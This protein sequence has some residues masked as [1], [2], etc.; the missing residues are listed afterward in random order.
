MLLRLV[1]P[2]PIKITFLDE[3]SRRYGGLTK[4]KASLSL[5]DVGGGAARIY[6]RY[7]KVHEDKRT[8]FGLRREDLRQLEGHPGVICFL[9]QGQSEPLFV[10]FADYE[11]VFHS[12][13][14][15]RDGQY[16]AQ[17]FMR[18]ETTD[19]Y[20]AG[21][22][23]FN[24]DAYFGWERLA[25]IVDRSRLT[26]VPELNHAQVQTL[27]GAIGTIKGYEVWIPASDK[28]GLDWSLARKFECAARIP[29]QLQQIDSVFSEIDVVWIERGLGSVR[30]AF[31]VEYS[32]PIYSGLLRFND[33]HLMCPSASTTY[34]IVS[35]ADRRELFVRQ[36]MRPTFT[37]SHLAEKCTFI[38]YPDV[39]AWHA[40]LAS[41]QGGKYDTRRV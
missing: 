39:F 4:L 36:L 1:V 38:E 16:K 7:S 33:L 14:P 40:R 3:L 8:F 18:D 5:F 24:V 37:I 29:C 9:W 31:E 26:Y 2:N 25:A 17:V 27:L 19:L 35:G 11:R 34:S 6:I 15:A 12:V 21:A 30:A 28:A 13:T 32:T 20:I 41:G 10:P 23:R 22:G